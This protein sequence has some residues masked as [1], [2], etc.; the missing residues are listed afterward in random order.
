MPGLYHPIEYWLI[1]YQIEK[2]KMIQCRRDKIVKERS[3][4]F[5]KLKKQKL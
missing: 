2:N 4:Y 1:K 5:N 3:K